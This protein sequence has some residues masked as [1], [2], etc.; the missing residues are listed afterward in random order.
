MQDGTHLKAK[1]GAELGRSRRG[2]AI[3]GRDHYLM[4]MQDGIKSKEGERVQRMP[5]ECG[6][7][8]VFVEV[9]SG[10]TTVHASRLSEAAD[11]WIWL[12]LTSDH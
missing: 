5:P 4:R 7:K 2:A 9:H 1:K 6:Q 12:F 8:S 10:G 3:S 11:C